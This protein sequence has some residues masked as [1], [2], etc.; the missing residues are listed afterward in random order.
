MENRTIQQFNTLLN[1][2]QVSFPELNISEILDDTLDKV[3]GFLSYDVTEEIT[4]PLYTAL[5]DTFLQQKSIN[6]SVNIISTYL[7][8]DLKEQSI[9]IPDT[10]HEE[11]RLSVQKELKN[12]AAMNTVTSSNKLGFLPVDK[13]PKERNKK[14]LVEISENAIP[15]TPYVYIEPEKGIF[16]ISARGKHNIIW[17]K[18]EIPQV[19]T[20]IKHVD[21]GKD[22]YTYV[23]VIPIMGE[24]EIKLTSYQ[25]RTGSFM[26]DLADISNMGSS[27]N[28]KE[29]VNVIRKLGS[30]CQTEKYY[31]TSIT[32]IHYDEKSQ[33][34]FRLLP[35]GEVRHTLDNAPMYM[36]TGEI[37]TN[38]SV[39][40]WE[41]RNK[42]SSNICK[43]QEVTAHEYFKKL[44][45]NGEILFM[46]IHGL[47][48]L[49]R[50]LDNPD[51][52]NGYSLV[53]KAE[54]NSGKTALARIALS[55]LYPHAETFNGQS[56]FKT[57][58]TKIEQIVKRLPHTPILIDDSNEA[59][60]DKI[61]KEIFERIGRSTANHDEV[62]GRSN[63]NLDLPEGTYVKTNPIFTVEELPKGV[64]NSMLSRLMILELEKGY[65]NIGKQEITIRD[66]DKH[67]PVV[68]MWGD[69]FD[70]YFLQRVNTEGY[71]VIVE[72]VTQLQ[73]DFVNEIEDKISKRWSAENGNIIISEINR[74]S[75]NGAYVLMTAHYLDIITEHKFNFEA[76]IKKLIYE[77]L[78]KQLQLIGFKITS[79]GL[80]PIIEA[81]QE[82]FN[83][84]GEGHKFNGKHYRI[85]DANTNQC[86]RISIEGEEILVSQW[87]YIPIKKGDDKISFP[88]DSEPF[89]YIDNN[90]VLLTSSG[91]KLLLE[92]EVMKELQINS[93]QKLTNLA[94][95]SGLIVAKSKGR[96]DYQVFRKGETIKGLALDR[97]KVLKALLG[98]NKIEDANKPTNFKEMSND[99]AV[100][101][102][103]T[104]LS[105][106]EE[107]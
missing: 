41:R 49:I 54:T 59:A 32:G 44:T 75:R 46:I 19:K 81:I 101:E 33:T 73:K 62:R 103:F 16:R 22:K 71:E 64:I 65:I 58:P 67:I 30:I 98:T 56:N 27:V 24:E 97:N 83:L 74:I 8:N 7:I 89:L 70:M 53:I 82:V 99:E 80:N 86:P 78:F 45:P 105:D 21:N 28:Q 50:W 100:E 90:Y 35:N 1:E 51:Y 12:L 34:Y 5:L 60:S 77:M 2:T 20:R 76:S 96:N 29:Y 11:L 36:L 26:D 23:L 91:K 84:I 88:K 104:S 3:L 57:T 40:Q 79:Q 25:L 55:V 95:K 93:T 31:G 6:D 10:L 61:V 66:I 15:V 92:T 37:K 4:I 38:V 39:Q 47:G 94:D 18:E 63:S 17:S 107:D 72:E 106:V 102:I 9:D 14:P 52:A 87:G 85:V 69:M 68:Y 13:V 48:C 42:Y 43:E